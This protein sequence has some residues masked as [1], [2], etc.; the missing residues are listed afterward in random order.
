[1]QIMQTHFL[2]EAETV[3]ESAHETRFDLNNETNIST[4]VHPAKNISDFQFIRLCNIFL[5]TGFR[6]LS[7]AFETEKWLG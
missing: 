4:S 3:P 6:N 1:M 5:P 2:R 7:S